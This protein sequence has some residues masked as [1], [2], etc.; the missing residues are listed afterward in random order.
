V[1]ASVLDLDPLL[2]ER[3]GDVPGSVLSSCDPLQ[4][5]GA[6]SQSHE[7]LLCPVLLAASR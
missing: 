3:S 4:V 1:E 7:S 5:G 2:P 6:P